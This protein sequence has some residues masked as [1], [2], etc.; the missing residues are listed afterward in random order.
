[1]PETPS[2][3]GIRSR[4]TSVAAFTV[5]VHLTTVSVRDI[6]ADPLRQLHPSL[7]FFRARCLDLQAYTSPLIP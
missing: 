4:C 2:I 6:I 5:M 1:M 3:V 7:F